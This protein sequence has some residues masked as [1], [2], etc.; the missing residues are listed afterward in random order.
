MTNK[1][2]GQYGETKAC[3]YLYLKGYD[4]IDRNVRTHCG[5]I[6]IIA[7]KDGVLIAIEVKT[8]RSRDFGLPCEAVTPAKQK[9]I[10]HS[11]ELYLEQFSNSEIS[12]R[13]DVIEVY[14]FHNGSHRIHHLTGCFC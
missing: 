9:H 3:E 7:K 12:V 6:D 14:V 1:E 2:L 11:L 10:R 13:F 5:E 8:R 4:L